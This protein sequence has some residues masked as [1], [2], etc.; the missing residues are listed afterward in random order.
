[1]IF[2]PRFPRTTYGLD[3]EYLRRRHQF[4][5]AS[6]RE[7]RSPKSFILQLCLDGD[8]QTLMESDVNGPENAR[9]V[10]QQWRKKRDMTEPKREIYFFMPPVVQR[11]NNRWFHHSSSTFP[12]LEGWSSFSVLVASPG[13]Q[14]LSWLV[15]GLLEDLGD[16]RPYVQTQ[17]AST[18]GNETA[19]V[20]TIP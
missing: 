2:E 7:N 15:V 17:G 6:L 3:F 11:Y 18:S 13:F 10:L 19:T 20:A 16:W 5:G 14:S 12:R 1:M 8:G 9:R 4:S